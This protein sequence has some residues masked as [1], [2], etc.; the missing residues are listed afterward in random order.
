MLKSL[1]DAYLEGQVKF[2]K[3]R[4]NKR[5]R[6]RRDLPSRRNS[7]CQ[8]FTWFIAAEPTDVPGAHPARTGAETGGFPKDLPFVPP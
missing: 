3:Y 8:G 7:R 2:P 6:W 4:N 1:L 5:A